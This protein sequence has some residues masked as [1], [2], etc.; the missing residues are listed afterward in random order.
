MIVLLT[1]FVAGLLYVAF[2]AA[3]WSFVQRLAK[4]SRA[5]ARLACVGAFLV[6]FAVLWATLNLMNALIAFVHLF[7]FWVL[8]DAVAAI[9]RK[10]RGGKNAKA[11]GSAQGSDVGESAQP[12]GS[13]NDSAESQQAMTRRDFAG[14]AAILLCTAYL[15][16][17]WEADHRVRATRYAL[18]TEKLRGPLR[19]AQITDSHMGATFHADRFARYM[20]EISAFSPDIAVVT[21]DFVDDDTSRDDMLAGCAALSRL[22]TAHGV[23]FVYGNHDKGYYPEEI[24]GW[25]NAEMRAALEAAGVTVLEDAAV[26]LPCGVTVV[27]RRDRSERARKS[28]ADLLSGVDRGTYVVMLDH[29][30]QD[31]AAEAAAGPD[32]VLCGHTHGGQLIPLPLV[33][34]WLGINDRW[35]GHE[36]RG[37]TDFIVSSGISNWSLRFKTGCFS[38]YV[39]IDV[40]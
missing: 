8:C 4:G 17:G 24:R 27:G 16:A 26:Q 12:D 6:L 1:L 14:G 37:G 11:G 25:T 3:R 2:R 5:T 10:V 9:V 34:G 40:G 13:A 7:I 38:E 33:G 21:G 20:D 36:R 28:A 32:L 29:Q 35:Y 31:F 39:I 30:P 18:G 15:G 23:F 22:R 19:I